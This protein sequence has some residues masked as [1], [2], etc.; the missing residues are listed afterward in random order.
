[1][2]MIAGLGNPGLRYAATRHN[3]GFLTVEVIAHRL[4]VEIKDKEQDALTARAFYEG[5][6]LL[7]VK[8]QSYMNLSG[9]PIR[10]LL[11]FYKLDWQDL[12]VIYDDM[13]LPCGMLRFRR[14]GSAGGHNGMGSI[15]E[16]A[17]HDR[18]NRLKIGIGHSV[19]PDP[20]DYV[21]GRFNEQELPVIGE[22]FQRAADAALFW[23]KEG[24][25]PAMNRF[26]SNI[27]GPENEGKPEEKSSE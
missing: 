22:A 26:N 21:I 2:K 10:R 19:F 8:P 27:R 25:G 5:K 4:G 16:Q 23:A 11:H 7:L 20:V 18:I 13:D 17:G 24:I 6:K 3:C 14:G 12:L 9:F 1:M 15:I